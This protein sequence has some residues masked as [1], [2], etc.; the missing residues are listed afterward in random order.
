MWQM[1]VQQQHTWRVR[2]LW[3]LTNSQLMGAVRVDTQHW[4]HWLSGG[5][6]RQQQQQQQQGFVAAAAAHLAVKGHMDSH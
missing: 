4:L 3:T 6:G 1:C 2:D 5:C